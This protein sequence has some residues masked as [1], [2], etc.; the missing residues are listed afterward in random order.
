MQNRWVLVGARY[1][2]F[3]DW[4]IQWSYIIDLFCSMTYTRLFL[5][6]ALTLFLL[7]RIDRLMP[8]YAPLLLRSFFIECF[9]S[10][11]CMIDL[12]IHWFSYWLP[13]QLHFISSIRFFTYHIFQNKE[14]HLGFSFLFCLPF[15]KNKTKIS[16]DSKSYFFNK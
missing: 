14:S 13:H 8:R 5:N 1:M 3:Y 10:H 7:R 16:D 4:L 12:S 9:D 6:C 15:F 2:W 11:I